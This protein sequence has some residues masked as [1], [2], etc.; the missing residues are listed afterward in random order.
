MKTLLPLLFLI[1]SA[2]VSEAQQLTLTWTDTATDESGFKIERKQ[3][4]TGTFTQVGQVTAN[5][6]TYVDT[7]PARNVSYCYRV[8]AFNAAGHSGYSNEA[9]GLVPNVPNAPTGLGIEVT[10]SATAGPSAKRV[11][12][13]PKVTVIK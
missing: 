11:E 1:L 2:A 9:C 13:N 12:I 5:T 8:R 4:P 7:V 10:I 6:A 3:G